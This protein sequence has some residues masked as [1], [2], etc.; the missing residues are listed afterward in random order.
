MGSIANLCPKTLWLNDG[1]LMDMGNTREVISAYIGSSQEA[2]GEI[3]WP[4]MKTSPGSENVH[5]RAIRIKSDGVVT[6]NVPIDKE[7]VI[8]MDY[9]NYQ[10]GA[11]LDASI[12]LRDK[13]NSF[14]LATVNWPSASLSVDEWFGKKRLKGMYRSTCIIPANFLNNDYYAIDVGISTPRHKWE[15]YKES[16]ISFLVHDTG[17]MKKEYSGDW[18]GVVRPKLTWSTDYLGDRES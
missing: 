13:T 12:H 7:V 8:E 10:E 9:F 1:R 15:V 6:S 2:G 17:E 4:D 3:S 14:V 18:V 11:I 16:I 5:L